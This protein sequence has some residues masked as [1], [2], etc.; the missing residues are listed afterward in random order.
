[1]ALCEDVMEFVSHQ[2]SLVV[3]LLPIVSWCPQKFPWVTVVLLDTARLMIEVFLTL[4]THL[5]GCFGGL[6]AGQPGVEG[7]WE[8]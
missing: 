3:I 8:F 1:M 7:S 6:G 5:E 4:M 2:S